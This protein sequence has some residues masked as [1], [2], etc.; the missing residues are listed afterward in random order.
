M[1]WVEDAA[2]RELARSQPSS[3]GSGGN[4]AIAAPA[5]AAG[6]QIAG[7]AMGGKSAKAA[8]QIQAQST[9][10][11]LALA[12]QQ[13]ETRNEVYDQ[14]MAQYTMMRNVLAE[15]YGITLPPIESTGAAGA[16]G[17]APANEILAGPDAYAKHM[18]EWRAAHPGAT[19]EDVR[20]EERAFR[21]RL[22]TQDLKQPGFVGTYPY[23]SV[24]NASPS[25]AL[26]PTPGPPVV[27]SNP[28]QG[29]T[30]G[31]LARPG[32]VSAGWDDWRG[33][34]LR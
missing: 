6:A 10:K 9:D 11:A 8:A 24:A 4:V 15:R 22:T 13:E 29:M 2:S 14:K 20:Q 3:G 28:A 18:Q 21:G 25:P 31:D 1:G 16:T 33:Y 7:A 12:R 34:G 27:A 26:Q 23:A 5:I 30:L 17:S 19:A 32:G